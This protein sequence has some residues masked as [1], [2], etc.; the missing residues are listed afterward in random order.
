MHF[1]QLLLQVRN[2]GRQAGR[3]R[4]RGKS[5]GRVLLQACISPSR[6]HN[7]T[8]IPLLSPALILNPD[9]EPFSSPLLSQALQQRSR[10]LVTLLKQKYHNSLAR[11]PVLAAYLVQVRGAMSVRERE[12]GGREWGGER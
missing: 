5:G 8:P 1:T 6:H 4:E 2:R 11:D 9:S 7:S 10:S 12:G 3:Q